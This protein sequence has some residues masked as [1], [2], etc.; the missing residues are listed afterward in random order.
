MASLRGMVRP[1]HRLMACK[2]RQCNTKLTVYSS[3]NRANISMRR[4]S[5]LLV[6][7]SR[8][9]STKT[10][11]KVGDKVHCNVGTIGHIDHGKTTLTAAITKVMAEEGLSNYVQY[12]QID[13]AP[14]EQARGITI[15]ACHV[16]YSSDVRHYAHTD[17]PGHIDYIKNMITG[18]SQMDGAILVVAATDG[19]MPQTREHLLLAKQIGVKNVVV[20]VNKA[21]LVD[22]EMLEL[23]EMEVRDLL[24]ELEFDGDNSPV[25]CGSALCA[26]EDKDPEIGRDSIKKLVAAIDD[27]IPTPKRETDGPA[28]LPVE[29]AFTVKGRGTVAVGTVQ[30]GTLNKGDPVDLIGFG[31]NI[32]TAIGD[33]QVFRKSVPAAHAGDNVGALLRGI[34]KEL[35][36]RGMFIA[37]PGSV[38]QYDAFEAFVYVRTK[39]EGGRT[40]PITTNY[41]NMMYVD[42]WSIACCVLLAPD[43]NMVMPGDTTTA[44][45]LLRKAMVLREGQQFFVR[46]NQLTS[47]TGIVTKVLPPTQTKITGFN[48][49]NL[50]PAKIEGNCSTVLRKRRSRKSS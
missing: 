45:I 43:Q 48:H 36:L 21:D 4:P 39:G 46:E 14:E 23:V 22:S 34:R 13:R 38:E 18:T 24:N 41:I 29:T 33:L 8:F 30:R 16:E 25:I 47:I 32:K 9:S 7:V 6:S 49:E 5:P 2:V 31:N 50:K 3:L 26:L 15:N 28:L 10:Q 42:T 40:K 19:T 37:Q 27:Y 11:A 17:C 44:T 1:L 20:Y 12:D 35:V